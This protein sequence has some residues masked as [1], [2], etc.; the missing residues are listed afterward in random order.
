M[1]EKNFCTSKKKILYVIF[2]FFYILDIITNN[3]IIAIKVI[4]T[5]HYLGRIDTIRCFNIYAQ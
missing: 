4:K 5:L 2:I 3:I 1:K